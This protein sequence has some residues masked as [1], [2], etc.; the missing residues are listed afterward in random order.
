MGFYQFCMDHQE[1][2]ITWHSREARKLLAMNTKL[3]GK[4][5]QQRLRDLASTVCSVCSVC[6]VFGVHW[7]QS[8]PKTFL[9]SGGGVSGIFFWFPRDDKNH[10]ISMESSTH[11]PK[12]DPKSCTRF[13]WISWIDKIQI[14]Q[15]LKCMF[16]I[17]FF[18]GNANCVFVFVHPQKKIL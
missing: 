16:F 13:P 17:V 10:G 2:N 11:S 9:V 6:S 7:F 1:F 4:M 8:S 15:G 12:T 14:I 5:L 3:A 18:T